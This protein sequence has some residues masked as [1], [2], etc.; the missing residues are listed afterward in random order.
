[1]YLHAST[2]I[3]VWSIKWLLVSTISLLNHNLFSQV[4]IYGAQS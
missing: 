4:Q 3:E 2:E 1:M